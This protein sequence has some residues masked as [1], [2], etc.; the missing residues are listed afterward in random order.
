MKERIQRLILIILLAIALLGVAVILKIKGYDF[1][2][3]NI[4][5]GIIAGLFVSAVLVLLVNRLLKYMAEIR[6]LKSPLSK[7]D[8]MSGEEF[9]QYLKKRFEKMG[10]K[11]TTTPASGD[12]GADLICE[13]K[14]GTIVVQ[15]KRYEGNVGTAAVQ[16]VVA[17]RDYYE[18]DECMVITNS[19][20]TKN[21]VNLAES[22]EVIL[23]DR[24][25]LFS[26]F[27]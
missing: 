9:E 3:K 26:D 1:G 5:S 23:I 12:Y 27:L 24:D 18:A 17:A 7:I 15:A 13:N 19:F 4:K 21:A 22:N 8:K 10:Y 11:V 6:Y 16:E 20:F 2:P 25:N 14:D